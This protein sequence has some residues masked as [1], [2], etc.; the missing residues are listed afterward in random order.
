MSQYIFKKVTTYWTV[1]LMFSNKYLM[2]IGTFIDSRTIS[3]EL[4]VTQS[5]CPGTEKQLELEQPHPASVHPCE[6]KAAVPLL[7]WWHLAPLLESSI[8]KPGNYLPEARHALKFTLCRSIVC[9]ASSNTSTFDEFSACESMRQ[10]LSC[11][12][13]LL[14]ELQKKC[15]F[16]F[17]LQARAMRCGCSR[18]LRNL[19]RN[20]EANSSSTRRPSLDSVTV[21]SCWVRRVWSSSHKRSSVLEVPTARIQAWGGLMTALKPLIPNIPRLDMLPQN[22]EESRERRGWE[23]RR[24]LWRL[25]S[26]LIKKTLTHRD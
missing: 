6:I 19:S 7:S 9:K 21:I 11:R 10:A 26:C 25:I 23:E 13:L 3:W 14:F 5:I 20:R 4:K 15:C 1:L 22:D 2:Y 16:L 12:C 8:T 18:L 17:V 24:K